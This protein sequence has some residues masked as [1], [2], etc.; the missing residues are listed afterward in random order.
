MIFN[1]IDVNLNEVT[2]LRQ[3]G[4]TV[5]LDL[6]NTP[7]GTNTLTETYL[8]KQEALARVEQ[9]FAELQKAGMVKTDGGYYIGSRTILKAE[10]GKNSVFVTFKD[11]T[12]KTYPGT[13]EDLQAISAAQVISGGGGGGSELTKDIKATTDV[14]GV[15]K[16]QTFYTGTAIEDVLQA[17]LSPAV[18]PSVTLTITPA[19]AV[20]KKGT[21]VN[22]ITMKGVVTKGTSDIDKSVFYVNNAIVYTKSDMPSGGTVSYEYA[23][24]MTT[25]TTFKV[26]TND[27]NGMS[28]NASKSIVFVNPY[29][30]GVSNTPSI[31]DF[32]GLSEEIVVKNS[33]KEETYTTT[34]AQYL[35]FAYDSVY[36]NLSKIEDQNK[37]DNTGDW[38]KSNLTVEGALYNVYITSGKKTLSSFKYT[39]YL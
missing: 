39:F 34:G 8:T 20:Y 21:T 26:V 28:A 19:T 31:S 22:S 10:Y 2:Q 16:G 36:G 7:K 11:G 17:V 15:T 25:D 1:N 32:T 35:V 38:V 27:T 12:Q 13:Q 18:G 30:S 9:C 37:F 6:L 3:S 24:A 5:L 29:Y 14:G 4:A 23:T 33:A